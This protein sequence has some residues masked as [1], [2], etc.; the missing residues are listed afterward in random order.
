VTVIPTTIDTDYHLRKTAYADNE[1][2][3]IGWTGSLTT[4]KHFKL[5]EDIL[6][7]LKDKYGDKIYFKVIG[8][9]NYYNEKLGIRG[10]RWNRFTEIDELEKIDIGIMPLENDEWSKGK[11]GFK[12][13]QYM[14]LEIPAVL[15]NVGVNNEIIV[16]GENGFIA[17]SDEEWVELLSR[18]IESYELR[19]KLGLAGRKTIEE[20]F[21]V[22]SQEEKYLEVFEKVLQK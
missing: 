20:R 15:A 19:R 9:G 14:A 3:C 8:E 22:K 13:L 18:L 7:K 16:H 4:I 5:A 21:S 17:N 6:L 11:C 2:I 1:R 12:G 10:V